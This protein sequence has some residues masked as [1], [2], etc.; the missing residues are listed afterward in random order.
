VQGY[1]KVNWPKYR[2]S[3]GRISKLLHRPVKVN[4]L[5]SSIRGLLV[6]FQRSTGR[7]IIAGSTGR[8]RGQVN[9]LKSHCRST[10]PVLACRLTTEVT[11]VKNLAPHGQLPATTAGSTSQSQREN[12]RGQLAQKRHIGSTGP[13]FTWG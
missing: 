11:S 7:Y 10:G 9:W 3:T 1:I 13:R 8:L 2:R 4:W 12:H 6:N 5:S